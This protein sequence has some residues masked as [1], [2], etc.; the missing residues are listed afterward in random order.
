MPPRYPPTLDDPILQRLKI[1]IGDVTLSVA[2]T[3]LRKSP[4]TGYVSHYELIIKRRGGEYWYKIHGVW[5]PFGKARITAS[6]MIEAFEKFLRRVKYVNHQTC[7]VCRSLHLTN[8]VIERL[9]DHSQYGE[10]TI[11]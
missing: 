6:H 4:D 11:L 8:D 3:G 1:R 2:F 5:D 7:P 9:M 10:Y